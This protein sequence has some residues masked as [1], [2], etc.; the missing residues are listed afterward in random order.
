MRAQT[1]RAE[2]CT[3]IKTTPTQAEENGDSAMK[4]CSRSYY[5]INA[6]LEITLRDAGDPLPLSALSQKLN[7]SQSYLEQLF[8]RLRQSGLV[9][10]HRGPGGGYILARPA[11]EITIAQ[12]V[13]TVER[14]SRNEGDELSRDS[15]NQQ[16]REAEHLWSHLS[17]EIHTFLAAITLGQVL[18]ESSNPGSKTSGGAGVDSRRPKA[19]APIPGTGTS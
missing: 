18:D 19:A 9:K 14:P 5:A 12:I 2:S 10:G 7:I 4:L 11:H 1:H 8:A 15:A 17:A 3:P 6:M 13:D 16:R